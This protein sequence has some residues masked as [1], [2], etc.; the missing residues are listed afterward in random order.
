MNRAYLE[1]R[2]SEPSVTVGSILK[3]DITSD[4]ITLAIM[5]IDR[6]KKVN[7]RSVL[8]RP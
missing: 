4:V 1:N 7:A 2:E 8:I 5:L 6:S 3:Y